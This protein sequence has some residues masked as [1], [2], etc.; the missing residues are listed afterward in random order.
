MPDNQKKEG[1]EGMM[2][3]EIEK[4]PSLLATGRVDKQVSRLLMIKNRRQ[5]GR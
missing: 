5:S 3:K 1:R 4:D 2:T